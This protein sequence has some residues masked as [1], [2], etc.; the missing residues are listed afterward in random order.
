MPRSCD[1]PPTRDELKK[2]VPDLFYAAAQAA[3]FG[4]FTLFERGQNFYALQTKIPKADRILNNVSLE[5]SL[6]FIRKTTEF[7]KRQS[8]KDANDT[9]FAYRYLPKWQGSWVVDKDLY[10]Q[11]HK[12]VGHITVMEARYGKVGWPIAEMTF[13]ALD[14]WKAF[15]RDL[16]TS[17]IYEGSPPDAELR[18]YETALKGIADVC[19]LAFSPR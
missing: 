16:R 7:F 5:S 15:F 10:R 8:P 17:P 12:R 2:A 11:M 19:K 13:S 14:Q 18:K 1:P 9:L 6:L 4:Y 3:S